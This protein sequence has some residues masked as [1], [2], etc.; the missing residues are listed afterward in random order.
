[1]LVG[2]SGLATAKPSAAGLGSP[3]NSMILPT[4]PR[5][6]LK[7]IN[8]QITPNTLNMVWDIA[9]LLAWVLPMAAAIFAVI[10][11]PIFSPSTIAQAILNGIHPMLSMMRVMAIVAD[12]DWSTSVSTVPNTRKMSTEPNPWP[13]HSLTNSST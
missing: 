3:N 10:V 2:E 7:R 13:D 12:E 11:V 6:G 1:M 8:A 4:S 9:A 5:N